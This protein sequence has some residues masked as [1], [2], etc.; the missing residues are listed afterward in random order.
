MKTIIVRLES[1]E[2]LA[3]SYDDILS[4]KRAEFGFPARIELSLNDE[5]AASMIES[6]LDPPD[7]RYLH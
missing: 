6:L 7:E 5:D 3:I 4:V 2:E 1:G